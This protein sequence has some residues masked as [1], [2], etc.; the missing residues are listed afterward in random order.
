MPKP[1]ESI[2]N[3]GTFK[4]MLEGASCLGP[5]LIG[6]GQIDGEEDLV[7]RGSF[8][9]IIR[10][11]NGSLQIERSAKVEG[12]IVAVNVELTGSLSGNIQ[13]SGR[14]SLSAEARMKGDIAAARVSIQD[15]AQFRGGIKIEKGGI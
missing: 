15:G 13:A 2:K 11:K 14:V 12:D 5:S 4:P 6:S 7:I 3:E 9:G 8:K 10:L 1:E